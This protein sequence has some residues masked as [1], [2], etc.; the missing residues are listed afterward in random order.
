LR[1]AISRDAG[2]RGAPNPVRE[3]FPGLRKPF[4]ITALAEA[5]QEV[6]KEQQ[7][8]CTRTGASSA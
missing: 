2:T 4:D 8:P 6:L 7:S 5:F 3:G 1:Q